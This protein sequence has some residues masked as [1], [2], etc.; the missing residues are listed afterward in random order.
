MN[1]EQSMERQLAGETEVL[2]PPQLPFQLTW[3]QTRT[4][5]LSYGTA[6]RL[7]FGTANMESH[8]DTSGTA[9]TPRF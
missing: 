1:V 3:D 5:R 6:N 8:N 4:N 7:S 2:C 9:V